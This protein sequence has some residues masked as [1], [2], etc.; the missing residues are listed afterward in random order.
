MTSL[1]LRNARIWT[2]DAAAPWADA[3]LAL[4]GRFA[5]VGRE[6]DVAVPSGADVLDASGRLVVPGFTDGHAHLLATGQAMRAVNLKGV[7]SIEEAVRLVGERAAATAAGSWVRG[8]GWDQ[9]LWPD[10]S[11]PSRHDLDAVA[12]EHPVVLAHTSGH[13]LWLN[14][15]ALNTAGVTASTEAPAGGAIDA[16]AD[17]E[18]SGILRD[19]AARLVYDIMPSPTHEERV[20]TLAEAAAHAHSLGVTGVHAMD[21]G[22]GELRALQALRDEGKLR[23]RTRAFLSA[24][25]LDDWIEQGVRTGAGDDMLRVGGLKLLADGALGS[26]T[27]WM[28]EPYEGTDDTG[29]PLQ[30]TAE[31]EDRVRRGL[32][33]GLAPAVHAIGDRANREVLDILERARDVSPELPRRVEHAQLL[34]PDDI[35]RFAALGITASVQPIHATQDMAKV[36]RWWG[37]RGRTAYPFASLLSHGTNLAFG[38]DSPVETMSPVAG[39]HAA[40]CRRS[41]EGVP[42][43]GWHPDERLELEQAISA[44]TSGCARAT[45]E[46]ETAGKIAE[47][48][49]ADFVVLSENLFEMVDPMGIPEARPAVTVVAGEV[50]HRERE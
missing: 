3:A 42:S 14:T 27:A 22:G 29:L 49:H 44:Y 20:A 10:A 43:E 34:A 41:A 7:R 37:A 48:H 46:E 40:V 19:A 28:L 32:E 1:L 26:L 25:R 4:E 50:V 6:S 17:G 5:F 38:S 31:L 33:H 36:D 30:T 12:P 35:P 47:G 23:L 45:G 21:V 18:P 15:A 9:H 39:I 11:F 24:A 2:G 8:A 13:C 16:D